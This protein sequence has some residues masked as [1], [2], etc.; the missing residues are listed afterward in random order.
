MTTSPPISWVRA[1]GLLLD[2]PGPGLGELVERVTAIAETLF[3]FGDYEV[4]VR[5]VGDD[6]HEVRVRA[7]GRSVGWRV[8]ALAKRGASHANRTV[9]EGLR[10]L[11]APA[12]GAA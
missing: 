10:L 3:P 4:R 7:G 11:A 2:N 6:D 8:S 9:Y 12:A 1:D 5:P